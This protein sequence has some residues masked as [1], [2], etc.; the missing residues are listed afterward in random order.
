MTSQSKPSTELDELEDLLV[1]GKSLDLTKLHPRLMKG[2]IYG[3]EIS[4]NN[5]PKLI[6]HVQNWHTKEVERIIG[7]NDIK[8]DGSGSSAT[9]IYR[10]KT[11]QN[12]DKYEVGYPDEYD[13]VLKQATTKLLN[14]CKQEVIRELELVDEHGGVVARVKDLKEQI[15]L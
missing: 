4:Y 5:L 9:H 11:D 7:E 3:Y 8:V 6:K 15:E 14:L 2:G 10:N 12:R 13:G 1:D